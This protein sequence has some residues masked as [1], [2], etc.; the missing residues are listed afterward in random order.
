M[1]A[2]GLFCVQLHGV[3][4]ECVQMCAYRVQVFAYV[5]DILSI[6]CFSPLGVLCACVCMCVQ[7]FSPVRARKA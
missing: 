7:R 2:N 3:C 6:M 5:C 1:C 4:A